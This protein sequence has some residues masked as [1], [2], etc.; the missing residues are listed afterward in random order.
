M[1]Q[2][3][4]LSP[5]GEMT[6]ERWARIKEQFDAIADSLG[7]ERKAR[8]ASLEGE[9]PGLHRDVL[10]MLRADEEAGE[11][12]DEPLIQNGLPP[13]ALAPPTAEAGRR[14]GPYRL[15]RELGHGGMGTVYLA[16]RA[17]NAYHKQVAVKIVR[18][19]VGSRALNDRFLRERQILANLE[20]PNIARLLDGGATEDNVPY[21]VMEYVAGEPINEYCAQQRL[22][23]NARL[24][25][26]R[27]LCEAVRHAHEQGVIHRDLKPGNILVTADGTPKLLDF[28]IAKLSRQD[29]SD[30]LPAVDTA[31]GAWLLTP[32]YASPE[33]VR[34]AELTLASDVYSLGVLLYE[35]LTGRRPYRFEQRTPAE[36]ERIVCE[37]P[38]RRPS[39]T[40]E[41]GAE[42]P[43]DEPG[44]LRKRL[45]GGLDE[46]VLTALAKD[47]ADRYRTVADLIDDLRVWQE[48]SSPRPKTRP[49]LTPRRTTL[50]RRRKALLGLGILAFA[51]LSAQSVLR[52]G[53]NASSP[54]ASNFSSNSSPAPAPSPEIKLRGTRDEEAYRLYLRGMELWKTREQ[55]KV[56]GALQLF[57]AA[58]SRDANFALGY[59]GMASVYVIEQSHL[60]RVQSLAE[61]KTLALKAL[62]IDPNLAEA[63]GPLGFAL[64]RLDLNW[65]EAEKKFKEA[66]R[67]DPAYLSAHQWYGLMLM[68]QGRFAEAETQLQEAQRL[69][70][71]SSN[72][73]GDL[74]TNCRMSRQHARC[75]EI[76]K[77]RLK[78]DPSNAGLQGSLA[79]ELARAG[80]AEEAI[81]EAQKTTAIMAPR[82][83]PLL[84]V[85]L[86]LG[87]KKEVAPLI[88]EAD[89]VYQ[90]KF[91]AADLAYYAR[92]NRRDQSFRLL[93]KF[94]ADR[95][96]RVF[97][98]KVE[99]D[100]DPI[101]DD[102]R[103]A[104]LLRRVG[105]A[106]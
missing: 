5:R 59:A 69:D 89:E 84:G 51:L 52:S 19:G 4:P 76:I 50:Y 81:T 67:H 53:F 57:G 27:V 104:A 72:V 48:G 23:L 28:G 46:I 78:Q 106:P 71:D 7:E 61:G 49:P 16:E 25:L 29:G 74:L 17:D 90:R 35:L 1:K 32:D 3:N 80:R 77:S 33:Q 91:L 62:S 101:R 18:S 99:P 14:L 9:D 105:L 40:L 43:P 93:E 10:E 65:T 8:L 12:L 31:T 63:Y 97:M 30:S 85:Y 34:G 60:P 47:P 20:H 55:N 98:M 11:F 94:L 22:D 45:R 26:F 82:I 58:V 83:G 86:L 96:F 73:A 66:I 21:L 44:D 87:R 38:V 79:L 13:Q 64:W 70:P 2:K 36:V 6:P 39:L 92:L 54:I 24:Q 103:Y 37:Q 102:P 41:G 95:H 100:L 75:I 42:S 15:L 88:A 56:M 68:C